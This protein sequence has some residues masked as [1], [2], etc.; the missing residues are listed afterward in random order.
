M[1][2]RLHLKNK[3]VALR[4]RMKCPKTQKD[5]TSKILSR[6]SLYLAQYFKNLKIR[7]QTVRGETKKKQKML[8]PLTLDFKIPTFWVLNLNKQKLKIV[9]KMFVGDEENI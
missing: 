8:I 9:L 4:S 1:S 5:K 3:Y 6:G 2:P 7:N